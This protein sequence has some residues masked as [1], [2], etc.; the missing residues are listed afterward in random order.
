MGLIFACACGDNN[1]N[2]SD[3]A[4]PAPTPTSTAPP[5]IPCP[6]LV[7]YIVEGDTS[8]F[9]AGWTGVYTD[10]QLG[11]GGS[12]T[13]AVDCPGEFLGGCGECPISGPI[14][15]TTVVDNHR[16]ANASNVIC[17]SD[18]DCP[19]STCS[20]FFGAPI[21]VSGGGVP[22]CVT[23]RVTNDATGVIIPELGSG[24]SDLDIELQIFNGLT[25]NQPCPVCSGAAFDSAGTCVG[26]PREGEAC[27]VHGTT[28]LGNTSF[29]CPPNPSAAIGTTEIPL[30]PTT[31]TRTVAPTETCTG[32]GQA[33]NPCYC[34]EQV[35]PNACLDTVCT[36]GADD[37]GTC[38]AGPFDLLCATEPF[39]GC[40]TDADCSANDTCL[41]STRKCSGETDATGILTG[42][43]TRTGV[44]ST[45]LAIQVSAFCIDATASAAVNAAAGLPGPAA[46]RLPTHICI[47][48]SCP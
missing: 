11:T 2:A 3:I 15:S 31:G 27:T 32:F 25:V 35:R 4:T 47:F 6:Q 13:F 43:L 1:N 26:G 45:E 16:C 22:I 10:R 18:A 7:T 9:D 14:A 30:D 8:D 41:A 34:T 17:T 39:R 19:G 40:L 12:L 21:P 24:D 37:E 23:N 29:D 20:F 28:V 5:Q 42:S 44:P 48:P 36:I 46:V 38:M 33:G